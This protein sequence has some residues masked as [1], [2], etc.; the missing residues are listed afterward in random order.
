MCFVGF[1][2]SLNQAFSEGTASTF[3]HSLMKEKAPYTIHNALGIP[4]IVQH[5]ANLRVVGSPTQGKLQEVA[6]GQSVDLDH[7]VFQSSSR[8]KLSALQRQESCLFNLSIGQCGL[9]SSQFSIH[10]FLLMI[11]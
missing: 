5:S 9:T 11:L 2:L 4:L 7:S 1:L 10:S 6:V 8:G 3:G